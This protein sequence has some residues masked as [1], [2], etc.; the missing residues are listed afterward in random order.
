M[1]RALLAFN[2]LLAS[3]GCAAAQD[4][5]DGVF[6]SS[7]EGCDVLKQKTIAE[8]GQSLDFTVLSKTGITAGMQRCD[9]VTVTARNATSWLASAFCEEPGYSFPDLF[10][11]LQKENGDLTVT[12]MTLQPGP[13]EVTEEGPPLSADDLDPS[14]VGRDQ[15]AGSDEDQA[16]DDEA[17]PEAQSPEVGLNS[18]FRCQDV[19]P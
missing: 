4:L 6:A 13:F 3:V 17:A 9:F 12:R 14:E 18:Y 5:P 16:P 8:L 10:A 19:K 11:I 2:V 15:G 1:R 7:K